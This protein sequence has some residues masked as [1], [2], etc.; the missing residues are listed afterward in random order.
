MT[1]NTPTRE[2]FQEP[3]H[4]GGGLIYDSKEK[5]MGAIH[6]TQQAAHALGEKVGLLN[7]TE[8]QVYPDID[9]TTTAIVHSALNKDIDEQ[10]KYTSGGIR[11][12]KELG[13]REYEPAHDDTG[14]V[15]HGHRFGYILKNPHKHESD[16]EYKAP[17]DSFGN[18]LKDPQSDTESMTEIPIHD[19]IGND[20]ILNVHDTDV[21]NID[22]E[23]SQQGT[24]S[25]LNKAQ[26]TAT[27]FKEKAQ[28][29]FGYMKDKV[30]DSTDYIREL[31]QPQ[32]SDPTMIDP[33]Y[34]NPKTNAEYLKEKAQDTASYIKEKAQDTVNYIKEKVD[35]RYGNQ[36]VKEKN[37]NIE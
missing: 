32:P 15:T 13:D 30:Q 36:N 18:V 6:Y 34:D 28:D 9:N 14:N 23:K 16:G 24:E 22:K 20:T 1:D 17:L 5:I 12:E 2:H 3:P 35:E 27:Y 10:S 4:T 25:I 29:G 31:T 11:V 7:P 26:D 21:V 37:E 8:S 33:V 19:D